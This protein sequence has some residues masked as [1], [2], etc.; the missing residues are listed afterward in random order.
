M[1][2]VYMQ[3]VW[4]VQIIGGRNPLWIVQKHF[5]EET[6]AAWLLCTANQLG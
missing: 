3:I 4:I 2:V 1:F 6:L 5:V